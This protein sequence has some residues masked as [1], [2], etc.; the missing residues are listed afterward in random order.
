MIDQATSTMVKTGIQTAPPPTLV[1]PKIYT[2]NEQFEVRPPISDEQLYVKS[3]P[4]VL[5]GRPPGA[6][7]PPRGP[8]GEPWA[9]CLC[10][11]CS[12]GKH[13]C[14]DVT[15]IPPA[16]SEYLDKFMEKEF[17]DPAKVQLHVNKWWPESMPEDMRLRT[18]YLMKYRDWK[19]KPHKV[20][21]KEFYV[22]AKAKF[23]TDS[24]YEGNF[25]FPTP[26][27]DLAKAYEPMKEEELLKLKGP[28]ASTYGWD[29]VDFPPEWK[30]ATQPKSA[31]YLQQKIWNRPLQLGYTTRRP[32]D[33]E[34]TYIHDYVWF[35]EFG[36]AHP[37]PCPDPYLT[38]ESVPKPFLPWLPITK[39]DY[40]HWKG[41]KPPESWKPDL[42]YR[43]SPFPLSKRTTHNQ[44]YKDWTN[45]GPDGI[46]RSKIP[47][48]CMQCKH[49]I[50]VPPEWMSN[51]QIDYK[52][53]NPL[54]FCKD[55][56][57]LTERKDDPCRDPKKEKCKDLC[58]AKAAH[59]EYL[60]SLLPDKFSMD[61][62]FR[63][64]ENKPEPDGMDPIRFL[65][66]EP[67]DPKKE[68][69]IPCA[70]ESILSGLSNGKPI[71]RTA[72]PETGH[73]Y[74]CPRDV[75][76]LMAEELNIVKRYPFRTWSKGDLDIEVQ[77]RDA[78]K[79]MDGTGGTRS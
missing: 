46:G 2:A 59:E 22:P 38:P 44:S 21:K 33:G 67:C 15:P 17:D 10:Q 65:R 55:I 79:L 75:E 61:N 72:C 18:E 56:E 20:R 30:K 37:Y 57:C 53:Y 27:E 60:Q 24:E 74:I 62:P 58:D 23:K 64:K 50:R 40:V 26:I 43:P 4:P 42:P 7:L 63:P 76:K 8:G 52:E 34:T 25:K 49:E 73:L 70:A 29:Y 6:L 3:L 14:P 32:F 16:T 77:K 68:R 39:T 11:L 45:C 54:W 66:Y 19:Q 12:C 28:L 36:R 51:Y 48:V 5:R 1:L 47:V 69:R 41:V 71:G 35:D 9:P 31:Q 13:V 78:F